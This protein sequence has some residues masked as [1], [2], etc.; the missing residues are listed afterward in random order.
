LVYKEEIVGAAVHTR[1]NVK[2]VYVSIGHKVTLESAIDIVLNC[3]PKYRI[4]EPI[5]QA[6]K[7][8]QERKSLREN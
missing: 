8:A 7:A 2:P 6:H 5:R 3:A 4:P 1:P